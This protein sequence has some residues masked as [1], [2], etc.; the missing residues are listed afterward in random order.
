MTVFTQCVPP[1]GLGVVSCQQVLP[2]CPWRTLQLSLAGHWDS[3]GCPAWPGCLQS[4][5]WRVSDAAQSHFQEH[6][7]PRE[8]KWGHR[9]KRL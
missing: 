1:R 3:R 7:R 2:E 6:Q 9:I 4:G 8:V 5:H